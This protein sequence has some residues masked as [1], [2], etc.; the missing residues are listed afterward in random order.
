MRAIDDV[1]QRRRAQPLQFGGERRMHA[2]QRLPG[3]HALGDGAL[4][5]DDRGVIAARRRHFEAFR[6]LRDDVEIRR[7]Q[8]VARAG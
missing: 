8:N 6:E 1:Q 4:V 5:G 7:A 3:Q 2:F